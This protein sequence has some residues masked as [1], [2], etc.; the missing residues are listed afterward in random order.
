MR[1]MESRIELPIETRDASKCSYLNDKKLSEEHCYILNRAKQ[2]RF[3]GNSLTEAKFVD[4]T[5]LLKRH[6]CRRGTP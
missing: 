2:E 1:V 4:E 5:H 6:Q 3:V